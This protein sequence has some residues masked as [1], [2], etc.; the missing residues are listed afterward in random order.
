M[1]ESNAIQEL[2]GCQIVV[3]T[4][5]SYLYIGTLEAAGTDYLTL[6]NVDAH[7]THDTKSSKEFYAHEAKNLGMRANRKRTLVRLAR[8]LSI[9]KMDDIIT[10]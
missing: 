7:D 1:P 6:A 5:S 3:D 8:V 4:D 2:I 9:A 10:F